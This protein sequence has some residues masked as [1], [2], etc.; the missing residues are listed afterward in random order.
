MVTMFQCNAYTALWA[1]PLQAAAKTLGMHLAN[2]TAEVRAFICTGLTVTPAAPS[3][4][5][6]AAQPGL[7]HPPVTPLGSAILHKHA[8]CSTL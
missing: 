2:D 7:G 5:S 3:R 4:P 6:A 1:I 8:H